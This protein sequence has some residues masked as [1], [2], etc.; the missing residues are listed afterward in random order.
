MD[1]IKHEVS[2]DDRV[3][4]KRLYGLNEK[5]ATKSFRLYYRTSMSICSAAKDI[6]NRREK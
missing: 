1:N 5:E 4:I 3:L 6:A 2:Y